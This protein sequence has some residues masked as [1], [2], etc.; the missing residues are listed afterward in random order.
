MNFIISAPGADAYKVFADPDIEV[1]FA[2]ERKIDIPHAH[3]FLNALK[4]RFSCKCQ[5][6]NCR[7]MMELRSF[8]CTV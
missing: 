6:A 4:G 1:V 3:S 8:N 5:R 7:K 2:T